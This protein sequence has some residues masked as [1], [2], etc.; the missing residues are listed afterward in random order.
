M[1]ESVPMRRALVLALLLAHPA[2]ARADRP[3]SGD[4]SLESGRTLGNGEVL[5]A[6][7]LGWPGFRADVVF[8][9]T[10]TLSLGPSALVG[11]GSTLLGFETGVSG[12]LSMPTRVHV[13]GRGVTDVALRFAPAIVIGEAATLGEQ[14]LYANE[15][16]LCVGVEAGARAGVRVSE[17]ATVIAGATTAFSWI[18]VP[19]AEDGS[20]W[21]LSLA[22][23]LGLEALMTRDTMM[24]GLLE[25]GGGVDGGRDFDRPVAL[26]VWLGFGYLL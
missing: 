23:V 16:G 6:G 4:A 13:L 8:A 17:H 9:P 5:L 7:A 10:S 12:G 3:T 2:A 26:R 21:V 1:S 18:A 15:L 14:G 20:G 25:L 22:A 24:L 11:Y 19:E